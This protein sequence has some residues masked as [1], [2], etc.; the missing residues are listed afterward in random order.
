MGV[1]VIGCEM[2]KNWVLMGL[3]VGENGYIYVIDMDII[4]KF[5]FNR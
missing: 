2:L 1:G 5:N 4:E 3:F